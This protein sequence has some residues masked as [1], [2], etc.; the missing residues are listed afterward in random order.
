MIT[1]LPDRSQRA[2]FTGIGVIAPTGIGTEAWWAAT[3]RGEPGIGAI[4]RFDAS[5]Y[6]VGHA[7]EVTDFD[8]SDHIPRR[9]AL[10]TDRWTWMGLA[11]AE[12]AFA[13]AAFVPADHDPYAMAVVTASSSGGNEFGQVEIQKLWGKGPDHVGAYQSIAWFYAATTGQISIRHGMKGHSNVVVA[14]GA[15]G[16]EALAHSRRVIRRGM[17][18]VVSGGV[19]AP[20]S[21]YALSC[22]LANGRMST[23]PEAAAYRPF[24]AAATGY[25]PGE[26]GAILL[27]ESLEHAR[28]RGAPQVYGEIAGYAATQDAC[29][30][31]R[32]PA[33]GGRLAR[34]I[35]LALADAGV[36]PA[37][38]DAVFADGAGT[39]VGDQLEAR[40]LR[41]ALGPRASEVPITVPKSMVGRLYAG[42][43]ALDV[44]GALLAIR[45]RCLP[46]TINL[47]RVA[48]GDDLRFVRGAAQPADLDTVL[49]L[50]RGYGGFNGALVVRRTD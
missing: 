47:E 31:T 18:A 21:P 2:V 43:A 48:H 26:G 27:V 4:T 3:L 42:G 50:A 38:V 34:A 10:Q 45:D 25:L 49:V 11:A 5:A 29:D 15:G 8:A 44:A 37:A 32:P 17:Q 9:L 39:P 41:A 40:A 35:E 22:Q 12:M 36:E 13:D 1:S 7:G 16:L 23:A 33:D 24:D 20:L 46:P 6:A 14:E 30:P 19:E 28:R